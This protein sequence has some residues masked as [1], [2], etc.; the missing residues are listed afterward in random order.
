[1]QGV[2]VA[3]IDFGRQYAR[4]FVTD[5]LLGADFVGF[6]RLWI[7][8]CALVNRFLDQEAKAIAHWLD[9][10]YRQQDNEECKI[11]KSAETSSCLIQL[12]SVLLF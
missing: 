11:L 2:L 3:P 10:C 7:C 6:R 4:V 12:L 9:T 5:V 1:M 8:E